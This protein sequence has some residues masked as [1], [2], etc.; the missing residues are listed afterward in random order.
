MIIDKIIN[1]KI[2]ITIILSSCSGELAIERDVPAV[3]QIKQSLSSSECRRA[4]FS[5]VDDR[6]NILIIQDKNWSAEL[7]E[8][9]DHYSS[10]DMQVS[11]GWLVVEEYDKTPVL[12]TAIEYAVENS[13][14]VFKSCDVIPAQ[15]T[16]EDAVSFQSNPFTVKQTELIS[17]ISNHI[18]S[19][20]IPPDE[21]S[22]TKFSEG[23]VYRAYHK[24]HSLINP[25]VNELISL[26]TS[27]R[28]TSAPIEAYNH[29][30]GDY[31]SRSLSLSLSLSLTLL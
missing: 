18:D 20:I 14:V 17:L 12:Q 28:L 4:S 22:R 30:V 9:S 19:H 27:S 5:L 2:F 3:H 25:Y 24:N 16:L 8:Y 11:G 29:M 21:P 6:A 26:S 31:G 13:A 23:A 1:K 7:Q 15:A 10:Y